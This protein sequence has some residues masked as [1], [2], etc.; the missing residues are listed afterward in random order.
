MLYNEQQLQAISSNERTILC[1]A[2]A[3]AGK[4]TVLVNR[5]NRLINDGADPSSILALTFTNA[6]AFEMG[7]KFKK[8]ASNPQ[9]KLPEFRTFHGF[10]Y[11]LIVKDK[12]IRNR[13]G[14]SQIPNICDDHK[15]KEIDKTVKLTLKFKISDSVLNNESLQTKQDKFQIELYKKALKTKLIEENLITF[16]ILCYNVCELFTRNEDIIHKYKEQY[17]FLCVDEFQDTDTK[18][19]KFL[20]SFPETTSV[21]FVGDALQNIYAWRGTTNEYIK[22]LA[23][24]PHWEIIKLFKNYRSTKQICEFANKFSKYAKPTYRIEMEGQREGCPVEVITGSN[25]NWDCCVDKHH[26]SILIDRLRESNIETAVLCRTNKEVQF[27]KSALTAEGIGCTTSSKASEAADILSSALSN[28]YLAEWLLSNLNS[29]AYS[30]YI[31]LKSIEPDKSDK[32]FLEMFKSDPSVSKKLDKIIQV[33]KIVIDSTLSLEERFNQICKL[34]RIK[35]KC[36][37]N[38]EVNTPQEL[39][40]SIAD[41]LEE[42][43]DGNL[44]VGTIHS[45][46]GLEY[47]RVFIMGVDDGMF[48]LGTEE[49]NNLYYVAMTRA[50]EYLII[51]KR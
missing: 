14:Y 17:K 47:E 36:K 3:G 31:R 10:C 7:E 12:V 15:Y 28:K 2:G 24:T 44:Y 13:L 35:T 21:F 29:E 50:K 48:E 22:M 41:Q 51:F 43:T 39:I 40:N 20:A 9:G 19:Y 49:M 26:L 32:E 34:L 25:I 23:E 45:S 37:F 38:S 30:D 18:Q 1:L 5:V 16:D 6:A 4:S 8:I 46:K 33:R 27:I 42:D 11:S